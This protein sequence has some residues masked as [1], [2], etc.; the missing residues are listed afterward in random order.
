[1]PSSLFDLTGKIAIVTGASRGIGAAATLALAEAGA[2]V[3]ACSRNQEAL[4]LIVEDV[5]K[6]GRNARQVMVDVSNRSQ[7]Q[8]AVRET[9]RE[10]GKIDIL[11]NSAGTI[12]RKP[13]VEMTEEEWTQVIDLNLKGTF[14][15]CQ[16][17]AREMIARNQDGKIINVASLWASLGVPNLIGYASSKGGV[18]SL[19]RSLAA[20]W[21]KYRIN[22]NA[23]GPG[24]IR[25]DLNIAVQNDADRSAYVVSRI[26]LGRWGEP[27]DLKG[28]MVFLAS[29][30]SDY[31]TGQIIW[32]DGGW[33]AT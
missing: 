21:A 20:E 14:F 18:G 2:D 19:T 8:T 15:F 3:V 33:T 22:V 5:R 10:F 25:T 13:S 32:V 31:V 27:E 23:V 4:K 24:Y 9:L 30:A 17:V 1:M 26:P 6:L 29:K 12:I 7:I 16:E 28:A 11:V